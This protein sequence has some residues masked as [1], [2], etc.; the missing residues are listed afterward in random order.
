MAIGNKTRWIVAV[1]AFVTAF[2]GRIELL[3]FVSPVSSAFLLVGAITAGHFP[4]F[5][6]ALMRTGAIIVSLW[7]IPLSLGILQLSLGGGRDP[8]IT[9][10]YA[11]TISLVVCC[12][13]ALV[14]DAV[15][16]R[17]AL[18]AEKR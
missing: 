17:S 18:L 9:A 12:D 6:R 11:V 5:A 1:T 16:M 3:S 13:A 4:R 8:R 7:A 2:A 14:A 15:S 10:A